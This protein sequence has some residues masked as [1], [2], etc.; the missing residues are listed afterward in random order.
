MNPPLPSPPS[1]PTLFAW[2]RATLALVSSVFAL[3]L[4]PSWALAQDPQ[5]ARTILLVPAG[6]APQAPSTAATRA[7][8]THPAST[9]PAS[10]A[11]AATPA[12]TA[13][14]SG[15]GEAPSDAEQAV[16][17][18]R[19]IAGDE[20]RLKELQT[21]LAAPDGEYPQAEKE[22][23]RLDAQMSQKKDALEL[24]KEKKN[25]EDEA[26]L[27]AE[28][29]KLM[30]TRA[31][32]LQRYE[33]ALKERKLLQGNIQTLEEKIANNKQALEK[34]TSV[35]PPT[36]D[37]GAPAT[38]PSR[39]TGGDSKNGGGN[40][41]KTKGP[42]AGGENGGSKNAAPGD[43]ASPPRSGA[44]GGGKGKPDTID[45]LKVMI[46]GGSAA[47]PAAAAT[48][49]KE[50]KRKDVVEAEAKL[51][52]SEREAARAEQAAKEVDERLKLIQKNLE[53]ERE[54]KA[55]L[56]VRTAGLLEALSNLRIEQARMTVEGTPTGDLPR[57]LAQAEQRYNEA[58][59]DAR[60]LESNVRR[61]EDELRTALQHKG[62]S[63]QTAESK[64]QAAEA[65][66]RRLEWLTNPLA[67][68]SVWNWMRD[69]GPRIVGMLA[70]IA[71]VAWIGRL[72][73]GLVGRIL[74]QRGLRGTKEERENRAK[75]IMGV[76]HNLSNLVVYGLGSVLLLEEAG[77]SV[78]PLVGGVAVV[79]VAV[80]F[81]AQN[82]IKDYF[83]GFMILLEQQYLVNDIVK[84]GA[85]QGQVES[86]TL[87]MT[88][89]RDTDGSVHFIPHGQITQV[90]NLTHGWSRAVIDV[91]IGL[92]D[93][94]DRALEVL[95]RIGAELRLDDKFGR[96][97]LEDADVQGV[98]ELAETCIKLRLLVKT[99]P[100][101]QWAVRREVLKRIKKRFDL[102]G[103]A[104]PAPV[105]VA[106]PELF[107]PNDASAAA[108]P[109]PH[110]PPGTTRQ[111][112]KATI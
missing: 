1:F 6:E 110:T 39:T 29:A 16:Q 58:L 8:S 98:Q 9:H 17:L 56:D 50:P 10:T 112:V 87:R 93:D 64:R 21:Q 15:T 14:P 75:T 26:R 45:P 65:E 24:A 83:T 43:A 60:R 101:Q 73:R 35:S 72:A 109:A 94:V 23:N 77:I 30:P 59:S 36:P 5:A 92:R 102:E 37:G 82:L 52:S 68:P 104:V 88:C 107:P 11:A 38:P 97:I 18:Q 61:L 27:E 34:I 44:E 106:G 78:A 80:A 89:L 67:F 3:A 95:V 70:L 54:L 99:R 31:E 47:S 41:G 42:P 103:I 48:A 111:G 49:E 2:S 33:L 74:A 4:V 105:G 90:T 7:A 46:P 25:A 76:F 63:T 84:I 51:Q 86:I 13:I 20:K 22:F 85:L 62:F 28:I 32:A 12:G 57:K 71:V 55:M 40:P 100:L 79:G 53:V 108:V 96:L 69:R 81:G 19:S 91:S 66:R